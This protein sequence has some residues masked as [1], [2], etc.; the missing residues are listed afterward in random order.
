LALLARKVLLAQSG[1]QVRREQL[2]QQ[3]RPVLREILALP[4]LLEFLDKTASTELTA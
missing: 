4:G 1:L 2:E 3:E